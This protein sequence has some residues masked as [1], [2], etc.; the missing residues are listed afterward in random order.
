VRHFS[1]NQ[2]NPTKPTNQKG[3]V[4]MVSHDQRLVQGIDCELWV[5]GDGNNDDTNNGGSCGGGGGGG[6][7][8]QKNK[9]CGVGKG[10]GSGGLRVEKRGFGFYRSQLVRKI[11]Q[12]TAAIEVSCAF[13]CV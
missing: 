8:F 9:G 3:G 4:I 12:R 7:S 6:G 10:N 5:C 1:F 2:P 13:A 11:E